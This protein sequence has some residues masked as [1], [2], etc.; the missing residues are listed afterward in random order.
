MFLHGDIFH[1]LGNMWF[2]YLFGFAVEG[3]LR[4]HKF[5]LLYFVA[6]L[7]G[8]GAHF[9]LFSTGRPDIPSFGASGAIMG[10]LGAAMFM[11]P[12]GQ[13]AFVYWFGWFF[14]GVFTWPMW[15]VGLYYLGFDI[16][17]ALIAADSGVAH[18]AHI[19]GAIGGC[20][21]ALLLR[22]KR[23]TAEASEAKAML[24]E[25]KDLGVLSPRELAAMHNANPTDPLI[26]LHWMHKSIRDPYGVKPECQAAFMALLPKMLRELDAG[27]VGFC[28]STLAMKPGVVPPALTL[29]A[30]H[31][32]EKMGE[33]AISMRLYDVV[34]RDP[35]SRP[36]EV[37]SALFRVGILCETAL[38]N[39]QRA[40]E[41]YREVVRRFELSPMADQAQARLKGMLARGMA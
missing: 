29:D 1:I 26:A 2:L 10:L 14:R 16:V 5:L 18:L 7:A 41:A 15:G 8:S 27:P 23:D 32:L 37:E 20:L 9:L 12:F 21:M 39:P 38:N 36:S 25:T 35:S 30:A 24:S 17:M 28:V 4:W 3:R 31:R 33:F 6:G 40:A 22:A 19:G 34:A 11:F 13:M